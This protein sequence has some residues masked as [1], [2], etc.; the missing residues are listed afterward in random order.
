MQCSDKY[1][2]S[3][4]LVEFTVPCINIFRLREI[5]RHPRHLWHMSVLGISGVDPSDR[6]SE[7]NVRAHTIARLLKAVGTSFVVCLV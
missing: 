5:R 4:N 3:S 2:R 7:Q 1:L 6:V